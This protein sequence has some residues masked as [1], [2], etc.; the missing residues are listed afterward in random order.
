MYTPAQIYPIIKFIFY[1][2]ILSYFDLLL[3]EF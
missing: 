2:L 1:A 3:I